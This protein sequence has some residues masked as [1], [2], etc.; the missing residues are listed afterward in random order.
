MSY[1]S[2][3]DLPTAY[4]CNYA[5][6]YTYVYAVRHKSHLM[7]HLINLNIVHYRYHPVMNSI[8]VVSYWMTDCVLSRSRTHIVIMWCRAVSFMILW[9]FHVEIV[10]TLILI[11]WF[12][13][14]SSVSSR[15]S[16]IWDSLISLEDVIY[17]WIFLLLYFTVENGK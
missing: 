5:S 7:Y 9:N 16:I 11:W 8:L 12:D 3:I 1:S 17:L 14:I 4:V 2:S 10:V 15:K 13:W 6:V